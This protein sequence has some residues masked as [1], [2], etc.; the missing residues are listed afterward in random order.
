VSRTFTI[1]SWI[2]S[3]LLA[4]LAALSVL[5]SYLATK[6]EPQWGMYLVSA[7]L[8]VAA[9][10]LFPPIWKAQTRVR[11]RRIRLVAAL[12]LAAIGMFA[13]VKTSMV[14][15]LPTVVRR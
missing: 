5:A 6:V 15:D 12:I 10:L 3:I 13:P 4:C 7:C 2:T 1:L 14:V 9:I 8:A 11:N